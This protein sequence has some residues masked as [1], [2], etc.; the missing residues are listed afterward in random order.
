MDLESFETKHIKNSAAE[1]SNIYGKEEQSIIC[2]EEF[3]HAKS[4]ISSWPD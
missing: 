3:K 1:K 2:L 4:E